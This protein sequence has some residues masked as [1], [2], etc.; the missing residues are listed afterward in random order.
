MQIISTE[1]ITWRLAEPDKFSCMLCKA[2]RATL[3]LKC[4]MG[5]MRLNLSVCPACSQLEAEIIADMIII[6]SK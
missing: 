4:L 3:R 5:D 6:K 2:H 1:Q